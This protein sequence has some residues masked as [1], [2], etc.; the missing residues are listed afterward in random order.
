MENNVEGR[1]ENDKAVFAWNYMLL[2][3]LPFAGIWP[4][5]TLFL[6]VA[7][8]SM[9]NDNNIIVQDNNLVWNQNLTKFWKDLRLL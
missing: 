7:I 9:V 5:S 8:H 1:D 4:C 2:E 3:V 6:D